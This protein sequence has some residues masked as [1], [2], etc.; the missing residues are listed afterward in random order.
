MGIGR[1]SPMARTLMAAVAVALAAAVHAEK[2]SS[3]STSSAKRSCAVTHP[4]G[5]SPKVGQPPEKATSFNHGNG[6]L[7]IAL[8]WPRRG[9]LAGVA[10][11]G[12]VE[13]TIEADGSIHLKVGW[14]RG[15]NGRL[16]IAGRR[17]DGTARPLRAFVPDG[18]GPRGFQVTGLIFPTV[19]CWQITGRVGR[20]TLAFVVRVAHRARERRRRSAQG[21]CGGR[22]GRRV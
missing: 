10:P 20:A 11:D 22:R 18:Y 16:R 5:N 4:N 9:V 19:G 14:Y 21:R 6:S 8:W 15:L 12:S 17:L 2:S 7:W 1:S 13:A 3:R